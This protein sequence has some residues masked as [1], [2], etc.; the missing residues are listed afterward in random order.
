MLRIIF[1]KSLSNIVK[2]GDGSGYKGE[3]N[4]NVFLPDGCSL[5]SKA[6]T[7]HLMRLIRLSV[8]ATNIFLYS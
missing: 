2:S 1:I 7:F 4:P 8:L 6:M 3:R 5:P